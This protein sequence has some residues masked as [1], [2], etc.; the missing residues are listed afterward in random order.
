MFMKYLLSILFHFSIS[1]IF[2]DM[3]LVQVKEYQFFA[4][5]MCQRPL[6]ILLQSIRIQNIDF[7]IIAY[8]FHKFFNISYIKQ[9]YFHLYLKFCTRGKIITSSIVISSTINTL[10]FTMLFVFIHHKLAPSMYLCLYNTLI[11]CSRLNVS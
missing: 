1:I 7:P 11:I 6:H 8:P 10:V 9:H 3:F 5:F 4:T 2:F